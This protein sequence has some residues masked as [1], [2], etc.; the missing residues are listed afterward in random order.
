MNDKVGISCFSGVGGGRSASRRR[1]R[2]TQQAV[3]RDRPSTVFIES[4]FIRYNRLLIEPYA[5]VA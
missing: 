5:A 1:H 2:A 3:A 4:D